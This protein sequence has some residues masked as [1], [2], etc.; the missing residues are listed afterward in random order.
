MYFYRKHFLPNFNFTQFFLIN[1]ELEEE[2]E[3][4]EEGAMGRGRVETH[5]HTENETKKEEN[6]LNSLRGVR[7]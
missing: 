6:L 5:C 4:E 2:E 1:S 3:E 7:D